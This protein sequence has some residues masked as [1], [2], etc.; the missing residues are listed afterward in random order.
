M[1]QKRT[2]IQIGEEDDVESIFSI[3][4][5]P[6]DNSLFAIQSLEENY[7]ELDSEWS[8]E[9]ILILQDQISSL[10]PIASAIPAP[11]IPVSVYLSKYDK[12]IE[13]IAF[14]DTGAAKTIMNLHILPPEWWK[15][16][17]RIFSTASN[18]E[19]ATHLISKPITI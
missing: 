7:K 15:P 4:D 6:N 18:D 10:A 12:P 2:G 8:S 3:D 19:F 13:V 16:H 14:I 5:E 1:I 11:H 9:G 17:T